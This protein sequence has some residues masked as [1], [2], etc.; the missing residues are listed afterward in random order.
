MEV[1]M[2]PIAVPLAVPAPTPSPS[3]P[4][5]VEA[6]GL[7]VDTTEAGEAVTNAPAYDGVAVVGGDSTAVGAPVVAAVIPKKKKRPNPTPPVFLPKEEP[8][9][10][11]VP[12]S[13]KAFSFPSLTTPTADRPG[14]SAK[15]SLNTPAT[16]SPPRYA[17]AHFVGFAWR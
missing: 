16:G 6:A 1:G 9:P 3:P 5:P 17:C 7:A 12:L 11:G 2:V 8:L 4:V 13:A 14:A 15:T 10:K